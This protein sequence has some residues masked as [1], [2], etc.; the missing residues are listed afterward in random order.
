[1]RPLHDLTGSFA[2]CSPVEHH[3]HAKRAV[4][5]QTV[6]VTEQ[7]ARVIIYVDEQGVPISTAIKGQVPP[8]PAPVV[9]V[10]PVV[11]APVAKP[12]SN[13][14]AQGSVPAPKPPVV[15]PVDSKP[16]PPAPVSQASAAPS[17]DTL[18]PAG[19]GISYSPYR[20]DSTC[21]SLAEIKNDFGKLKKYGRVRSYGTD[22]N[23]VPNIIEAAKL[24]GMSVFLG[25]FDIN[26]ALDEVQKIIDA[27]QGSWYMI[28]TI[29][30]GNEAVN[31]GTASVGAVTNAVHA[32]RAKLR[33]AGYTGP[34]VTVD[35]FIAIINNPALCAASDYVA[36]NC[37][38][39]FDGGVAAE[40]A[41]QFVLE[42]AQRV[43]KACGGKHTIITET[44]WPTNGIQNKKA[45]PGVENQ[46]KAIA[47]LE[48]T[49]SPSDLILFSAFND[50]W[51]QDNAYTFGCEK[52]WG[53][54]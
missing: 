16:P 22:C 40:D 35:T 34:V 13:V 54:V 8:T 18:L 10:T 43:S 19:H 38:P 15:A 23:Q 51:K 42:Q 26:R 20:A 4:V 14:P 28:D 3:R 9:V 2:D 30:I 24:N 7:V 45:V 53:I 50:E 49:F 32:S 11:N 33:A 36:A 37:H 29:S 44:G 21:K 5:T 31:S 52:F 17:Q 6:Y 27:A 41:G 12:T 48:A 1:M 47:S 46:K 25:V 39:Y